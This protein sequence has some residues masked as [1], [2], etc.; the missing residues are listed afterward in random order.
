MHAKWLREV[1][2]I[3]AVPLHEDNHDE[4]KNT[5][6]LGTIFMNVGQSHRK[7]SE[8]RKKHLKVTL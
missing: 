5:S 7:V 4:Q 3:M 2:N 6:L 8:N 1:D